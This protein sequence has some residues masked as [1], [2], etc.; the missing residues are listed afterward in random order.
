[1][2]LR[3]LTALFL[4]GLMAVSLT[5]CTGTAKSDLP[6]SKSEESSGQVTLR[7]AWWGSQTRHDI[8][9]KV[10]EM[11]QAQNPDVHIEAEFYDSDSY[12]TKL[13]TLVAADDVWDIFQLG[14]NFPKYINNIEPLDGYIKDG[15][16]DISDTTENFLATTRDNDGTQVGI[17]IGTNTYGIAYD[18]E[19]FQKAGLEE[20]DDDWTWDEWKE[21]CLTI[22][23]KLGIYGSSKMDNFIAG[24]TQ[25]ASQTEKDA[26]FFK[27]T[28]DGLDFSDPAPFADY[29][30]MIKDLTDAGSYPDAGAIKE[31]KDIEGDY[32]VTGDAAMTWVS[33]NQ[34]TAI[35]NAAGREI[36]IAPVPR[37]TKDGPY[38]MGVQ[39][40][41]QLCISKNSKAREEAARFINFFVNDIEAN[42]ILNGERGVPIM[43]KVREVVVSQA[44]ES[45]QI[46]YDFVDRIGNFPKEDCNVISPDPKTEIEDQDKLLIEKV[47]YGDLTPED[48]A[49]QLVDFAKSKFQS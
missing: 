33:S 35:S 9:N 34:I 17:S 11:Y 32:L 31:I 10:I 25:R 26:N 1:M 4:A 12:F 21:D 49:Q 15:I 29:M 42:K 46:I 6:E 16:I 39:S 18:P 23:E 44:D 37:L 24:V 5:A 22:T 2:N 20:P 14:G 19:L 41:Q 45:N 47:Q 7:M 30:Q 13:D 48:A 28:N 43:S 40:S 36:K 3:K 8:T 38:G 27:K